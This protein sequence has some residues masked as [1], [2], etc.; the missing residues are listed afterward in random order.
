MYGLFR[1]LYKC[2]VNAMLLVTCLGLPCRGQ[3]ASGTAEL[4]P[5]PDAVAAPPAGTVVSTQHS[6][7]VTYRDGQL[8][9]DAENSTL[10]EVLKLLAEKTGAVIDVPPGSGL[11]RIVEHTGPGRA[12]DVLA[13]LLNGSPFDFVIVGSSQPPHDPTQILLFLRGPGTPAGKQDAAVLASTS[14]GGQEPHLYGA[15]FRVDSSTEN[16]TESSE[17]VANSAS[18]PPQAASGDAIPGAVLDQFLKQRR[19]QRQQMQQQQQQLQ[20]NQQQIQL[21]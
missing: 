18:Q 5:L 4:P 17:S 20:T 16:S 9:I 12:E 14:A 11:E 15:G 8:T 19:R 7:V 2:A 1:L 13:W 21:Q 6:P 3:N 10:A